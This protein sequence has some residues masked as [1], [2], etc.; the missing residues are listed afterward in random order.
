MQIH[1]YRRTAKTPVELFGL[2]LAFVPN[3]AGDVVCEVEDER[4]INRLLEISDAYRPYSG[5]GV[6]APAPA[7]PVAAPA[8]P[9]ATPAA[10]PG[11][12]D[13]G[14]GDKV[15][16]TVLLG[17][18]SLPPT[19][20][21][22]GVTYTQAQVV[23]LAFARSGMDREEWNL[24]D[25]DDREALIEGEVVKLIT[26][27]EEEAAKAAE[28]AAPALA[29]AASAPAAEVNP[30]IITNGEQ[31]LDLGTLSATKLREFAAA[32]DIELPGGN[33]TKVGDLRLMVAKALQA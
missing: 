27:A 9:T 32:N 1:A 20:D 29:P 10:P 23:A 7:A 19:F 16:D 6:P 18:E 13:E 12:G 15:F 30:L 5:E 33:S 11:G 28:A 21:V 31:T 24:N 22:L 8:V 25:E 14:E 4:A 3:S 26:A 17:S 2:S